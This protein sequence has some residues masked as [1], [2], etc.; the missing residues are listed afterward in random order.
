MNFYLLYMLNLFVIYVKQTAMSCQNK[1]SF[2]A[3]NMNIILNGYALNIVNDISGSIFFTQ[4]ALSHSTTVAIRNQKIIGLEILPWFPL[5]SQTSSGH[6]E[7][8][9]MACKD[10]YQR[11][12]L[13]PARTNIKEGFHGLQRPI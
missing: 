7:N 3:H 5:L 10:K 11:R 13:W 1:D 12:F 8:I 4:S 2:L 6:R 9:Y